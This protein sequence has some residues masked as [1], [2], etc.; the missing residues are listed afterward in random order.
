VI[1]AVFVLF[2]RDPEQSVVA[3]ARQAEQEPAAAG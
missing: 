2:V 3:A 1:A